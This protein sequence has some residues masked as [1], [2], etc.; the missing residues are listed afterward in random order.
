MVYIIVLLA[1]LLHA[2]WNGILK[3]SKNRVRSL[4]L[5]RLVAVLLGLML[6]TILPRIN[7]DAI[8]YLLIATAIHLVY[9]WSLLSAYK[10]G[11]FSQV[12]PISRGLAPLLILFAG[13]AFNADQLPMSST[14]GIIFVGFGIM[15]LAKNQTPQSSKPLLFA[16]VTAFCIAGY[17]LASGAGVRVSQS[18]LVYAAWLEAFSGILFTGS[19]LLTRYQQLELQ[20]LTWPRA[21][22]DLLSGIMASGGFA[23][24]LWAM[25]EIPIAA[26]AALRETSV[27]FAALIGWLILREGF[28]IRRVFASFLVFVGIAILLYPALSA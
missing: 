21:R 23:V 17:T 22:I 11:D 18:F 28:G 16:V 3:H 26:V 4:F 14:A 6:I 25:T 10:L 13:W 9:F 2:S 5:N 19:V 12:Y 27:I 7:S 24:A 15:L 8:P 20:L 1:A